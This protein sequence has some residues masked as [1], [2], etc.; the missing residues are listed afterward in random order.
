L[1][2]MQTLGNCQRA[3]DT[4]EEGSVMPPNVI[5]GCRA[6]AETQNE[7]VPQRNCARCAESALA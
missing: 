1:Q 4:L 7:A 5:A 6:E 2:R 3:A